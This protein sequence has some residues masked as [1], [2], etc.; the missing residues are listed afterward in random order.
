MAEASLCLSLRLPP[1]SICCLVTSQRPEDLAQLRATGRC[2]RS[3][4]SLGGLAWP[5]CLSLSPQPFFRVI[6]LDQ[7]PHLLNRTALPCQPSTV[8]LRLWPWFLGSPPWRR[9]QGCREAEAGVRLGRCSESLY[10]SRRGKQVLSPGIRAQ[11]LQSCSSQS[12]SSEVL[13]LLLHTVNAVE[14]G[15]RI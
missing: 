2:Y 12:S 5:R 14:V 8:T 13:R 15:P 7:A 3:G 4:A 10:I 9:K 11:G 6:S 1:K